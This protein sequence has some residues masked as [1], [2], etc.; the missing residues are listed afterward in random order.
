MHVRVSGTFT[1]YDSS[2]RQ[3]MI[4]ESVSEQLSPVNMHGVRFGY[5]FTS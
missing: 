3:V 4:D 5:P 2:T 1:A